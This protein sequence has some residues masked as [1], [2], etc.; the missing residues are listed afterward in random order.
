MTPLTGFEQVVVIIAIFSAP[1]GAC[2]CA[3]FVLK[4]DKDFDEEDKVY[5]EK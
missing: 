3:F 4:R 1:I 2:V 5:P